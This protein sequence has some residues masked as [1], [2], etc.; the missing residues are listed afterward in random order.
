[1]AAPVDE[2]LLDVPGIAKFLNVKERWIYR[3]AR[4]YGVPMF[5]VGGKFLRARRSELN[6]W[7]DQQRVY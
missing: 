1:M 3:S 2:E 7:L 5:L 4:D 6:N